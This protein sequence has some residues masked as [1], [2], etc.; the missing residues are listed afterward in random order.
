MEWLD[1]LP[2]D[3]VALITPLMEKLWKE[4]AEGAGQ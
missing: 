4:K 2:G 3:Q 1:N